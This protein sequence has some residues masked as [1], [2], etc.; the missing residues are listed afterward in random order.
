MKDA[1]P[2]VWG[3]CLL[4]D[5]G[6]VAKIHLDRGVV[7]PGGH[8]GVAKM[9]LDKGRAWPAWGARRGL[10]VTGVT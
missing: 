10:G 1:Y 6:G 4:G 8:R 9:H 3:V 7:W 5:R 2:P